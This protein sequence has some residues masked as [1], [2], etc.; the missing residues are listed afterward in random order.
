MKILVIQQKMIG[1]VL[2]STILFEALRQK[3]PK[4][5][6][7][8]LIYRH[9]FP[10]VQGNPNIDKSILFEDRDN[11]LPRF[12]GILNRIRQEGYDL[13]ID[14]YAKI[15]SSIIT[16]WS[17]APQRVSFR[18]WYT[19]PAYTTALRPKKHPETKAG[20]AVENRLL[21]LSPLGDT[22]SPG[23]KPRI[24]LNPEEVAEARQRLADVGV[25]PQQP[26]VMCSILGSSQQKTYPLPYMAQILDRMHQK[27]GTRLLFN[28]I[29]SQK[30]LARSL[31]DQCRKETQ[32]ATYFEIFGKSLREFMAL[33]SCCDALIGNEGGAVNMAKALN[34]PTFSIF[35]PQ[36]RKQNWSIFEDGKQN[37][38]VH[39]ED[40]KPE[41]F[42]GVSKGELRKK[43]ASLYELLRPNLIL[44]ELDRFLEL[45]IRKQKTD[46]EQT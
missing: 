30:D 11:R 45:N 15:G 17:G 16:A 12:L 19:A 31:L 37:L 2:T 26:L 4:A 46:K 14:V 28:Y 40:Y 38:S 10:V 8:Y 22:H 32:S 5:E 35:S 6:L 1:D 43:S 33:T 29:P 20:L 13:V 42:Q 7:H 25:D 3:Y 34:V 36:I 18:K 41:L 23:I 21:L 39:L 27:T 24:W 9:T 44:A